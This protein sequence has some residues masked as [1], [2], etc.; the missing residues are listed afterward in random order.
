MISYLAGRLRLSMERL[1]SRDWVRVSLSGSGANLVEINTRAWEQNVIDPE[2]KLRCE[3]RPGQSAA[4][5]PA[6]SPRTHRYRRERGL[7]R[8]RVMG[9]EKSLNEA[10]LI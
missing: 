4:P 9:A 2:I 7:G 5:E 1:A 3:N 8:E 6:S 10:G